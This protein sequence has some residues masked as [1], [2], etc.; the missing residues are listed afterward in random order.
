MRTAGADD[1]HGSETTVRTE[2][3]QL[4]AKWLPAGT[5]LYPAPTTSGHVVPVQI[6]RL[7]SPD[8]IRPR[9]VD[10]VATQAGDRNR[11][12]PSGCSSSPGPKRLIPDD[13]A[14]GDQADSLGPS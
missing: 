3:A 1:Y 6:A 13:G 11:V 14:T 9:L 7:A 8:I 4:G 5:V 10:P 12:S 2:V